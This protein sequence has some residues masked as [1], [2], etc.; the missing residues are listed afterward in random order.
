MKTVG[1]SVVHVV[2]WMQRINIASGR[3]WEHIIGYSRAVRIGNMVY[4]SGTTAIS[5]KGD[6]V[7]EGDPYLQTKAAI[8]TIQKALKKAGA[9]LSDVVRTRIFVKNIEDWEKVGRAHREFFGEIRPATTMVEVKRLIS[10]KI[11]VEIE[12]EAILDPER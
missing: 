2:E 6:I 4:V 8:V 5:E 12:A 3:R 9:R 11:L 10:P 7:G 1:R